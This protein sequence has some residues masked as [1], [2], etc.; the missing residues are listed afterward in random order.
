MTNLSKIA[1]SDRPRERLARLGASALSDQEL[2][3]I[4]L[5]KGTKGNDVMALAEQ[6]LKV[7]AD[8]K[9]QPTVQ[10]LSAIKGVG[11][12][13]ATSIIAAL[14]FARRR[15]RPEG[16]KIT[17]P[18]DVIPLIQHYADRKQE[19]FICVSLNGANEVI[20]SRVVTVGGSNS[21]HVEPR[22][23]FADVVAD[24]AAA[25]ILA[26]NH[27]AGGIEPSKKDIELTTCLR[28]SGETL[29]IKVVDHIIFNRNGHFSFLENG[30]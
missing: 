25:V 13:K 7:I 2:L 18:A 19:H 14:E 11:L 12:A 30:L 3:A 4:L 15:I 9:D 1:D 26:H 21:T 28:K 27:P 29:G 5:G 23:V 8:K 16:L 17:F 22:E 10:D 6:L 20:T 24:R